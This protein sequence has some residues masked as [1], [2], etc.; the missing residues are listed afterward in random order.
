M[1]AP[2]PTPDPTPPPSDAEHLAELTKMSVDSSRTFL[3]FHSGAR[4][5]RRDRD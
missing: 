3:E 5:L 2:Q 1:D 4:W